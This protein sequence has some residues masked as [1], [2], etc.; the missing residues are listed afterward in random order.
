MDP[1]LLI[2]CL[3]AT[4][5]D[6]GASGLHIRAW[7]QRAISPA[8]GAPSVAAVCVH[9]TAAAAAVEAC[10]GTPVRVATVAA[11]PTG[12]DPELAVRWEV[13]RAVVVGV[14]ELDLAADVAALRT[15]RYEQAARR[16]AA[17]RRWWPG[18]LKVII[19]TGALPDADAIAQAT[20]CVLQA[21]ADLVKTSTG[22]AA[23]GVTPAAARVVC[24][25]VRAFERRTGRR[26]GV[27]VSGGIR[28]PD[29]AWTYL[30]IAAEELGTTSPARFRIGASGLLD[31]L[32]AL[33]RGAATAGR[34]G[35]V[36]RR[37]GVGDA[38]PPR[39]AR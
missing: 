10:R 33:L 8:P 16:V 27:K 30:C 38:D 23:P 19:E 22:V 11:F 2:A 26:A 24:R 29:S 1:L 6:P 32:V 36:P 5:L 37:S 25:T 28:S 3:D 21:G 20:W 31:G 7:C 18:T 17:V 4:D 9:P 14:D 34:D 13:E 15:G 39:D 35:Q 12:G